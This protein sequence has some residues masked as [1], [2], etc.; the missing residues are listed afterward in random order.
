M[1]MLPAFSEIRLFKLKPFEVIV[2]FPKSVAIVFEIR[3]SPLDIILIFP[4][5]AEIL[6][7][8]SKSEFELLVISIAPVFSIKD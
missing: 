4:F 3:L 6:L 5:L 8:I 7:L 1:V 2:I